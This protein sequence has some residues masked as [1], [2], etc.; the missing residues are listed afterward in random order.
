MRIYH[1]HSSQ[2]EKSLMILF[3]RRWIGFFLLLTILCI[4]FLSACTTGTDKEIDMEP[5][6]KIESIV[7]EKSFFKPGETVSWKAMLKSNISIE[8][9]LVTR[10][11]FLS[12]LVDEQHQRVSLGPGVNDVDLSWLPPADTPRGYGLDCYL[13]TLEGE[14]LASSFDAFD[15]L[16]HWTQHPRYGFLTDF[17]PE[18]ESVAALDK[19]LQFRI[20]GL[21]FYD[22][23]YRHEQYLTDQ[24]PYIDPLGRQ[25]SLETV[26]ELID[27]AH[28]R[29]MAA[30]PY[31]A[32]YAAS[33]PFYEAHKDWALYQPD[34]SPHYFGDN[35][36]VIMDPRPES[37]WTSHLLG[38]FEDILKKTSFDGIHLDQYG[39]PKQGYDAQGNVFGLEQPLVD[40]IDATHEIVD[41]QLGEDG[42]VIFN[43]VTNWPIEAVAPSQEDVVYIEVW[44][45]YTSFND[46]SSLIIQAQEL[47]GGKP[48]VLAAY[49]DP[50]Y[51]TNV[52][53]NDAIIFANGAGHIELGENGGYLADPYFPQYAVLSP[54]L[55]EVLQR[56]Y[57][58]AIRYQN[59]IG[60]QTHSGNR[61]YVQNLSIA[62][63]NTSP[64]ML[65]N[66][67]MPVIRVS[68]DYLAVNLINLL[69]LPKGEWD[70]GLTDAPT[71]LDQTSLELKGLGEEIQSVWF[72]TP[73][74]EDFS[75]VP[76]EFSLEDGILRLTI[77]HLDYWG[78]IL[79]KWSK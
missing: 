38:E 71:P 53:L 31:T 23:M 58:F 14:T 65:Y 9:E 46:L 42:A 11:T 6:V 66:K 76:L 35:F 12:R 19:L 39:A 64:G 8:L 36:L 44:S 3:L 5:I 50:F 40:L 48:V 32:V 72:A 60:P 21:Q 43:A 78:M 47:G 16:E 28:R 75:L 15:V 25:L 18:R 79:L 67:V 63:I 34:G 70:Q 55:S 51:E 62:G 69:G 33:I 7:F 54:N 74:E 73:D 29:N 30:M 77:P 2:P 59:V 27:A 57:A 61:D 20:N 37:P 45:P 68:E 1:F 26:E 4:G 24:E 41:Q 49:M 17:S 56:Y 22:W 52:L 10:I 13:K